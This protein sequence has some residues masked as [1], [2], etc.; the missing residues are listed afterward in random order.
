NPV[1]HQAIF[2]GPLETPLVISRWMAEK[3]SALPRQLVAK[4][5]PDDLVESARI[6]RTAQ[7]MHRELDKSAMELATLA[8]VR[9]AV[10]RVD[11]VGG[12]RFHGGLTSRDDLI[13]VPQ[14]D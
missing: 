1:K 9:D 13:R 11:G 14:G 6:V 12:G 8:A 5:L 2:M 10:G 4:V 7:Q 3:A